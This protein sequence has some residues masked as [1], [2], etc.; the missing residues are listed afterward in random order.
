M[1]GKE[2]HEKLSPSTF[3][4]C[5]ITTFTFEGEEDNA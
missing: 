5:S 2:A 1:T 3:V 4:V